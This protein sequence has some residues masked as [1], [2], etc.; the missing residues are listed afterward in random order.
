MQ[1]KLTKTFYNK[2]S[3]SRNLDFFFTNRQ[4][5][6]YR[7]FFLNERKIFFKNLKINKSCTMLDVGTGKN[8]ISLENF[9]NKIDHFDISHSHVKFLKKKNYKKIKYFI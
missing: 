9:F 5:E 2:S 7:S 1:N 4:L 8:S 6:S 3:Y